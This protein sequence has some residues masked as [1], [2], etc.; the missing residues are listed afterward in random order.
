MAKRGKIDQLYDLQALEAQQAKV[1]SMVNEFVS[2]IGDVKPI[3]LKLEGAE[4]TREVLDGIKTL[5]EG[6]AKVGEASK[7]A[8]SEMG[9]L[10]DMANKSAG[11]N[12]KLAASYEDL[13]RASTQNKIASQELNKEKKRLNEAYDQGA[14]TLDHYQKAL[15]EVKK[16]ENEISVS[17]LDLNRSLRNIEKGFQSAEGALNGMRAELNL[18]LQAFDR[19]SEAERNG[20]SGQAIKKN[21]EDLTGKISELEQSTGRFQRNVGNYASGFTGAFKTL[22]SE[23]DNIQSKIKSGNFSG[24]ALAQLRKEETLLTEVTEGLTKSFSST[25]AESRAYQ[26]A[27]AKLGISLGQDSEVFKAFRAEVGKGVDDIKDVKDSIKLAASDT[28]G[29][30]RLIKA[31]QGL[32]GAYAVLSGTVEA[33]GGDSEQAA[34][35]Q[36]KLVAIMTVLQGL[37]AVQAE[38]TNKDSL[39]KKA[40]AAVQ[41]IWNKTMVEGAVAS[42][43]LKI[44]LTGGLLLLLPAIAFAFTKMAEAQQKTIDKSKVLADVGRQ[45][46]DSYGKE[47]AELDVLV[48]SIQREGVSKKEKFELLKQ[49][50]DK[51]PGYFDNIKTEKDLNEKLAIAYQKAAAGVLL[52]AKANAAQDLLADQYKKQLTAELDF[53]EKSLKSTK[54]FEDNKADA[55]KVGGNKRVKI[56]AAASQEELDRLAKEYKATRDEVTATAGVLTKSIVDSTNELEKLGG[57]NPFGKTG[58]KT[59]T[60]KDDTVFKNAEAQRKALFEIQKQQ[61]QDQINYADLLAQSD[62]TSFNGRIEAEQAYYEKKKQLLDLQ[63]AYEL[64]DAEEKGAKEKKTPQQIATDKLAIEAK[65]NSDLLALNTESEKRIT[66]VVS[67]NAQRRKEI[68]DKY[69]GD[70]IGILQSNLEGSL[71]VIQDQAEREQRA[72]VKKYEKGKISKEQYEDGLYEIENKARHKSLLAE[73]AFYEKLITV[74]NLPEEK[75]KEALDKLQ[76]LRKQANAQELTDEGKKAAKITEIHKQKNEKLKELANELKETAFAFLTADI[77]RQKNLVQEQID[78]VDVKK[79]KEIEAANQSILNEQDKA[80]KIAIITAQANA[81]KERLEQKK[82]KLDQERARYDRLKNIADII[83]STA[84]AVV[85]TLG[86]KPWTPT[87][88]ALAAIVGAIGAAQIARVLATPLPKYKEGTGD[89]KGGLAVVGDGGVPEFV[90]TPEGNIYKTPATD[91]LVDMPAHS[92]VF[93]NEAAL[94]NAMMNQ[95]V[96][97]TM[98]IENRK[99]NDHYQ[100]QNMTSALGS[101]LDGIEKAIKKIPQTKI[102]TE[103]PIKKWMGSNDSWDKFKG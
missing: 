77:E 11:A 86:A 41:K 82:R 23:L 70:Q 44:A 26:Q 40:A 90:Q 36:K 22:N 43:G 81:E 62:K 34:E 17:N 100:F 32:A 3:A 14:I 76:E 19:L 24:D 6:T 25:T 85:S 69:T 93:K 39:F 7:I 99:P 74:S 61:L 96:S 28:Q 51:Y 53:H 98:R 38:L 37:Q 30:D 57:K 52:K 66:S 1:L 13:I 102:L 103:G 18:S 48:T 64:K 46:A 15:G 92:K 84:I 78:Q 59:D 72:L 75:K 49:L 88:I 97:A 101:K 31:A 83:Q 54:Y 33:F 8:V 67:E 20:A 27:A 5:S 80:A 94:M 9:K 42:T 29:F 68:H 89:H 35:A 16:K 12:G 56:L 63:K 60:K 55:Y 4:K 45:A 10:V 73:I 87:N 79:N 58:G 65:Y 21:I 95:H 71:A 50:Q 47:R 2:K 91:T